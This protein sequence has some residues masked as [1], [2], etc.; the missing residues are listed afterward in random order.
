MKFI[1]GDRITKLTEMEKYTR[2]GR[3]WAMHRIRYTVVIIIVGSYTA[4]RT[5][6]L[7]NDSINIMN[8]HIHT[9]L[10]TYLVRLWEC[11]FNCK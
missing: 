5:C 9:S 10:C 7:S 3:E 2:R 11:E 4:E 1:A 6:E 8:A